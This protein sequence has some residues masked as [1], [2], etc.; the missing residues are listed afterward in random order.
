MWNY[1]MWIIREIIVLGWIYPLK[2]NIHSKNIWTNVLVLL[3]PLIFFIENSEMTRCVQQEWTFPF[4]KVR[5]LNAQSSFHLQRRYGSLCTAYRFPLTH[6]SICNQGRHCLVQLRE[7]S[8]Q[9]KREL[10][11]EC[12][13]RMKYTTFYIG[14]GHEK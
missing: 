7:P 6:L 8:C 10:R 3:F 14:K 12:A 13:V 9:R 11:T 2:R 5:L 4:G 1:H